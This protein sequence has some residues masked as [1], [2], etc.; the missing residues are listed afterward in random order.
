MLGICCYTLS[1]SS[2][3]PPLREVFVLQNFNMNAYFLQVKEL[4]R[5]VRLKKSAKEGEPQQ[6]CDVF[7]GKGMKNDYWD[8]PD[9]IWMS[10]K[11][12]TPYN[13][14]QT[15][16]HYEKHIRSSPK[17][18]AALPELIGKV[19]GC[20][21]KPEPC[22][23]DVLVKLVNELLRNRV[24]DELQE[25]GLTMNRA[26]HLMGVALARGWDEE[27]LWLAHATRLDETDLFY[28][29]KDTFRALAAAVGQA[30][31]FWPAYSDDGDVYYIVGY[32]A[33]EQPTG[34][35][36]SRR[37]DVSPKT[38]DRWALVMDF[39]RRVQEE[40]DHCGLG[41]DLEEGLKT[42]RNYHLI[43][44][45]LT[46]VLGETVGVDMRAVNLTKTTIIQVALAYC[47]EIDEKCKEHT[48]AALARLVVDEGHCELENHHPLFLKG[49]K[50]GGVNVGRLFVERIVTHLQRNDADDEGGW[51]VNE[52]FIPA[53]YL[54]EWKKFKTKYRSINLY[55]DVLSAAI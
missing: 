8:L 13:A 32:F 36:W 52:K 16:P 21:C 25:C 31:P 17:L 11:F 30:I 6:D 19:L 4:T 54:E 9:S 29:Q 42:A 53:E 45:K 48:L 35:Y 2:P 15:L 40:I 55:E 37:L 24:Q 18:M 20:W 23:G 7:I 47:F 41:P 38:P 43:H 1:V 26:D 50:E 51:A 39:A 28:F 49:D 14:V 22:H 46:E 12:I 44:R 10:P 34:P 27:E 5:V 33:G 3:P